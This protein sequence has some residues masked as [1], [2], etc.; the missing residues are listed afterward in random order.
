MKK[1]RRNALVLLLALAAPAAFG[2]S[3][4]GGAGAASTQEYNAKVKRLSRSD[5]DVLLAHPEKVVFIELRR[6]DQVSAD[7]S[8]PVYLAIL[9]KDLEKNLAYIPKDREIVTVGL[10][11]RYG[12]AA[13]DLLAS[14]GFKVAGAVGIEDYINQG[15]TITKVAIPP[16]RPE[17]AAK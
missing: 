16:P 13:G 6:P 17:N 2:Q 1:N 14:K 15:G 7:G 3:A 5:V 4:S 11:A 9:A 10:H 12:G 8:F